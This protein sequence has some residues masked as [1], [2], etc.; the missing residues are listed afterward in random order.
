MFDPNSAEFNFMNLDST[1]GMTKNFDQFVSSIESAKSAFDTLRSGGDIGYNEFYNMMGFIEKYVSNSALQTKLDEFGLKINDFAT[2]VVES[3][4][5]IGKVDLDGIAAKLGI[6]ASAAADLISS[7]MSQGLKDIAQQQV[8]Y[9]TGVENMLKAMAAIDGTDA[10]M[11]LKFTYT[12]ENGEKVDFNFMEE[13]WQQFSNL[14]DYQRKEIE[15]QFKANFG[16]DL[17]E[18][19]LAIAKQMNSPEFRGFLATMS[20]DLAESVGA[21]IYEAMSN[22]KS[23]G[24]FNKDGTL[25]DNYEEIIG[26]FFTDVI[27]GVNL[28]NFS[29]VV[30]ERLTELLKSGT[31]IKIDGTGATLSYSLSGSN[32]VV[33]I[34]DQDINAVK[35]ALNAKLEEANLTIDEE[36]SN[37]D[38]IYTFSV[39]PVVERRDNI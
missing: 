24:I 30:Q 36:I 25:V 16:V 26:D 15:V 7:D 11:A 34:K 2:A 12:D 22:P 38:G 18:A 14:E 31:D 35:A 8:D 20:P 10:E 4:D 29:T 27:N 32:V 21:T 28:S 39:K 33:D 1:E 9:L 3:S 5:E 19:T 37:K 17:T 13:T 6:S 23:L